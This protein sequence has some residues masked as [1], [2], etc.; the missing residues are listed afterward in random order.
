VENDPVL[1]A[2][3]DALK[4][5]VFEHKTAGIADTILIKIIERIKSK[6]PKAD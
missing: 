6:A 4:I 1:H 2:R 3:L 5:E